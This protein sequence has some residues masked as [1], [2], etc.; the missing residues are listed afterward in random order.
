MSSSRDLANKADAAARPVAE[1]GMGKVRSWGHPLHPATVHY[2]IGLLS[3]SFALDAL[4][5]AP[6]L[7]SGLNYLKLLPP[8]AAIN[9]LSHYTGAA[10]MLAALPTLASGIAELYAM[11]TGQAKSKGGKQSVKDAAGKKDVAGEK[12]KTTLTHATLNDIV[13]G[14]AFWNWWVRRQSKDLILPYS[15]ALLSAAA[16]PLFLYSAYLGGSLVYEYGV[17]V[18]RQGEAAEIKETQEKEQ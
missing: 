2:P 5:I 16:I 4:Q 17:G 3:I 15:N 11:W 14:I 10:G 13:L 7:T 6:A 18:Q 8:A 9:V 1:V 12:L